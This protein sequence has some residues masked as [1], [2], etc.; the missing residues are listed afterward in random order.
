MF[1]CSES[2][3][4]SLLENKQEVIAFEMRC[5]P[6]TDFRSLS[7]LKKKEP[8]YGVRE[9]QVCRVPDFSLAGRE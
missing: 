9:F 7:S 6:E 3:Y 1:D 8:P 4:L 2:I 5:P